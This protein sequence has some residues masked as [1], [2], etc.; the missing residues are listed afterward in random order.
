MSSQTVADRPQTLARTS[1]PTGRTIAAT[2][3]FYTKNPSPPYKTKLLNFIRLYLQRGG[4]SLLS[5]CWLESCTASS[6]CEERTNSSCSYSV[7]H[8]IRCCFRIIEKAFD[9]PSASLLD[10]RSKNSAKAI[11]LSSFRGSHE[12]SEAQI[13]DPRLCG[14]RVRRR[15]IRSR[16]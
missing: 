13:E 3:S 12:L 14:G 11:A 6:R 4:N 15:P 9:A 8:T 16:R 1:M 10:L 5:S 7:D 2:W